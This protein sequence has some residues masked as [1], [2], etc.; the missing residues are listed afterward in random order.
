MRNVDNVT[1][2][3]PLYSSEAQQYIYLKL[4]AHLLVITYSI[5]SLTRFVLQ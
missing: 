4:T 3:E 2:S 5:T 1:S